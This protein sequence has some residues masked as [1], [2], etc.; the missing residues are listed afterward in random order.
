ML[1]RMSRPTALL[2]VVLVA[3]L[4]LLLVAC[5]AK[6]PTPP[7]QPVF[8]PGP[9][10]ARSIDPE[11]KYAYAMVAKFASDPLVLH[12]VQTSRFTASGE[13]DSVKLSA[14]VT[15]DVSGA[16]VDLHMV[17]KTSG[18]TTK[19]DVVAVG[20]SVYAREGAGH[21]RR[22]PRSGWEQVLQD[23]IKDLNPI[24]DPAHLTYVG[25]ETID[26]QKLHHLT[27]VRKFSYVMADGQRGTYDKF[28]IWVKED[29]TPV[30][31]KGKISAVGAY[32]VEIKGTNEVRFSKFGGKVKIT[33]PKL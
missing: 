15:V 30:L 24:K 6:G 17:I 23:S 29:G 33:A 25:I 28:D 3:T 20:T 11:D 21:W 7:P 26:K 5:A 32:G 1:G 9:T 18:K 31:A 12:A 8:H 14:T 27:A 4:A 22:V 13:T 2:R 19:M 10:P 16:D